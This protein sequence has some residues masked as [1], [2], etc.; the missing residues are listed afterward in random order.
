[1]PITQQCTQCGRRFTRE[2]GAGMCLTTLADG[3]EPCFRTDIRFLDI[4]S[5]GGAEGER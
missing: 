5:S 2:P 1:M 4:A 3:R